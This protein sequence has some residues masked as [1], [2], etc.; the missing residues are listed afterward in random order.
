MFEIDLLQG[1]GRPAKP[2]PMR[3]LMWC[4]LYALLIALGLW[5]GQACWSIRN[6]IRIQKQNPGP[7]D[8][9]NQLSTPDHHVCDTIGMPNKRTSLPNSR[10]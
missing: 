3:V 2:Q 1:T 5:L 7:T 4:G 10:S 8:Q 9:S 6:D